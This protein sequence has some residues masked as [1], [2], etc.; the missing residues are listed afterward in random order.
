MIFEQYHLDCLSHP[1]VVF[2]AGGYRSAIAASALQAL[3]FADVSD[4]LG[5]FEAMRGANLPISVPN[6]N[7]Q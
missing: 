5:G 6:R 7:L 4:V 1:T 3:G 2:C